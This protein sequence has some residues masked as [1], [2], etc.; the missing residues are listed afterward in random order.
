MLTAVCFYLTYG[1]F[2]KSEFIE[3]PT[4][5][6]EGPTP[7]RAALTAPGTTGRRRARNSRAA[8]ASGDAPTRRTRAPDNWRSTDRPRAAGGGCGARRRRT[9]CHSRRLQRLSGATLANVQRHS[10]AMWSDNGL[11]TRRHSAGLPQFMTCRSRTGRGCSTAPKQTRLL[12]QGRR[13]AEVRRLL[14]K[15][16]HLG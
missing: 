9:P 7:R 11:R 8:T 3:Y 15:L 13:Q 14:L 2:H 5:L 1:R 12:L 10:I 4:G 6:P 16:D